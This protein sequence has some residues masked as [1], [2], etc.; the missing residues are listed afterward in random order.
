MNALQ[1]VSDRL[2]NLLPK[3]IFYGLVAILALSLF[4]WAIET[5]LEVLLSYSFLTDPL[6][7]TLV[8]AVILIVILYYVVSRARARPRAT[9]PGRVGV[10]IARIEGDDGD[11]Y[12]RDLRGQAE[13]ELASDPSLQNVDVSVLPREPKS[14]DEA[15]DEGTW[16]NAAAVVWG[17]LGKGLDDRRVGNLKLTIVGGPMTVSNDVQFGRDVD[18]AGYEMRDVA[19]FVAGYALLSNGKPAEAV[20]HFDRILEGERPGLFELSDAL[21]FGGIACSLAVRESSSSSEL[22]EK[23]RRYFARYRDTWSEEN[24]PRLRAMG[25]FN[26][27]G[28]QDIGEG[29]GAEGIQE[30]L[31][32]YGEASRLFLKAGADEGYAMSRIEVAGIL[33][34]LYQSHNEATYGTM[35][36]LL[37][38]DA[39]N[40]LNREDHPHRYARLRFERGRLLVRMARAVPAY[41]EDA[42]AAFD[43]ALEIYSAVGFPYEAALTLLHRGGARSS[44]AAGPDDEVRRE[45]LDDYRRAL[46]FA[47]TKRFPSLHAGLQTSRCAVLLDLPPTATDLRAAVEAGEEAVSL[48]T[49]EE[50]GI[51]YVRACSCYAQACLA[52]TSLEEIPDDEAER[53][54]RAALR[55]AEAA[56]EVVS[57]TFHAEYH[58]DCTLLADQAR[59]RLADRGSN[60]SGSED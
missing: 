37:L 59:E 13:Q 58:H 11:G 22:L 51:E 53:L 17:N 28:V 20:V 56:G 33:S 31:R 1:S 25:F 41:Y 57:P 19:R 42:V 5:R 21:Q 52:Y 29:A 43:E 36:H 40:F 12:L 6:Y 50:N 3:P 10:W 55:R 15:R 34:D 14:H 23:A 46:S 26:L 4:F 8:S 35:A 54:L 45:V 47:P 49:P 2:V 30:A 24:A 48:Q 32:L 44:R 39:E 16:L 38:T 60:V 18:L 27:A 7:I 9:Q